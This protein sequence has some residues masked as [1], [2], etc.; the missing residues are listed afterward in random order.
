[1]VVGSVNM[2]L[3]AYMTAAPAPGET[4]AGREFRTVPGGKGA[5]QAIAAARAG[6]E[7]TFVG[8]VGDDVFA[9]ELG[10]SLTASGCD[11][12]RLRRVPGA[13]GVAHIRVADSGENSIVV[14]PGANA[15]V[16][17]LDAT[18]TALLA[19]Q[20]ALLLQLELPVSGVI[21][22]A[23]AA[24][25][26]GVATILTPAPV[27]HLPA[28]LL[29][30]V[31]LLVPNQHEAAAI[32]GESDPRRAAP[33]L[34]EHVPAALITR[35]TEG[36]LLARRGSTTVEVPAAEPPAPVVDTTGAGDVFCAA[37]AV[38]Q[39]ERGRDAHAHGEHGENTTAAEALRFA[40]AAAA[41]CVT[42]EG[43]SSSLPWRD[44]ID[45]SVV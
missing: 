45:R 39:A 26:A 38:A 24:R 30:S 7:V 13:S 11:T 42:R 8:A 3:V 20:D 29:T 44:E 43:A 35:G 27:A 10:R 22:A 21:S 28:E 1:M 6:A 37:F 41:L 31:D 40:A 9:D 25:E 16:R 15:S 32:T 19:G 2:D 23:R 5:N 12:S 34:L 17:D 14:V 18:D 33:A 4:V 36:A